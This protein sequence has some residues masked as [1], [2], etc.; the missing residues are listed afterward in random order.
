M[1]YGFVPAH[2]HWSTAFFA[3]FLH[4]GWWHLIGN[5]W[6]LWM[7]GRHVEVEVGSVAFL[8]LYLICGVCGQGLHHAF[9]AQ[10]TI[11]LV[12]ASGAI[13]GVAGLYYVLFP[14]SKFDLDVYL[15]WWHIKTIETR[16]RGAVGAWIGEQI[17]LG[18]LT[19][20]SHFSSTA[21]WAHVG[22][23][24]AGALLGLATRPWLVEK[25]NLLD[26]QNVY[27]FR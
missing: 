6:F 3:M 10:S 22:G 17:V 4:A 1:T 11:P 14:N 16:T 20:I 18:A 12:G 7:F 13:S 15:G 19:S 5:M 8:G 23:F 24:S 26:D 27:R 2:P 25:E 9:N 21:F